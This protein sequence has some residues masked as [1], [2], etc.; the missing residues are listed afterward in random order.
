MPP[1]LHPGNFESLAALNEL[2]AMQVSCPSAVQFVA[3]VS[4]VPVT[5]AIVVPLLI[6]SAFNELRSR[7]PSAWVPLHKVTLV[8]MAIPPKF[9]ST[10]LG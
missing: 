2:V 3:S 4:K 8:P 6:F 10:Q 9:G 1:S 7:V 5:P